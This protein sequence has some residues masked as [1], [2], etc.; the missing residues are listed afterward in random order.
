MEAMF[1]VEKKADC[2]RKRKNRLMRVSDSVRDRYS[3]DACDLAGDFDARWSCMQ[4]SSRTQV[5]SVMAIAT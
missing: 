2:K 5:T 4:C 3:L 1:P